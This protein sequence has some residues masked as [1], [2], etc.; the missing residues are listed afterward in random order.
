M[1]S[2]HALSGA[3]A[4]VAPGWYSDPTGGRQA[5]WWDGDE[6]TAHIQ[7]LPMGA[8]P[9]DAWVEESRLIPP[10]SSWASRSLGWGIAALVANVL[11]AP[12]VMSFIFGVM[13]LRRHSRFVSLGY[14]VDG[15]GKAVL[16]I[17]FGAVGILMTVGWI[18]VLR[19][20]THS[21]G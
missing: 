21:A 9:E 15:R 20:V 10:G 5:R 17:V 12:T 7:A 19:V 14:E 11:M 3:P 1:S 2:I 4:P 16:G 6:W 18:I 8:P 13:A